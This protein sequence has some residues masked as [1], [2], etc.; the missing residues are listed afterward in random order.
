[1]RICVRLQYLKNKTMLSG[2][3]GHQWE[4]NVSRTPNAKFEVSW[5]PLAF[6]LAAIL[7]DHTSQSEYP[8]A[9]K[10]RTQL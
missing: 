4:L 3:E 9:S 2:N 10:E 6:L 7:A 8:L 5:L 1:M